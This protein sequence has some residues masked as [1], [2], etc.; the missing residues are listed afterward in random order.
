MRIKT[1]SQIRDKAK[2]AKVDFVELGTVWTVADLEFEND[3]ITYR[4]RILTEQYSQWIEENHL[5]TFEVEKVI[6]DDG[7]NPTDV[8]QYQTTAPIT[9]VMGE[10]WCLTECIKI[11]LPFAVSDIFIPELESMLEI[12]EDITI[13]KGVNNA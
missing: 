8:T 13:G 3:P 10:K 12:M 4:V 11:G 6:H 7:G 1:E 9:K 2:T 5:D